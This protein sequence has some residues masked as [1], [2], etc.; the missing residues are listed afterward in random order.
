MKNIGRARVAFMAIA[1]SSS[2]LAILS[3]TVAQGST[4]TPSIPTGAAQAEIASQAANFAAANGG[5][6]PATA[7]VVA[8]GRQAANELAIPGDQVQ[9]DEAVYLV[10]MAGKFTGYMAKVP[11]GSETPAGGALWFTFDPDT[12]LV[13]DWGI[14]KSVVDLSALGS[15]STIDLPAASK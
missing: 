10:Q 15:V 13:L 4:Q 5:S 1:L 7:D 2:A 14:N 8:T 3:T 9:A 12:G 6:R 11:P